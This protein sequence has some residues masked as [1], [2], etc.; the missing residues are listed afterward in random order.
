MKNTAVTPVAEDSLV[1][2]GGSFA[3]FQLM[4]LLRLRYPDADEFDRHVRVRPNLSFSFP[5]RDVQTVERLA[6]PPAHDSGDTD[7][8]TVA[9]DWRITANFFGLYGVSSPLPAFY[10][11]DLF[12]ERRVGHSASRDFLDVIHAALYPILQG[13]WEKYRLWLRIGERGEQGALDLLLALVG[14]MDAAPHEAERRKDA[15]LLPYASLFAQRP[16]SALALETLISGRLGGVAV[17]VVPCI[18]RRIAISPEARCQLGGRRPLGDMLLGDRLTERATTY[19]L[20][21]GPLD[22]LRFRDLLP[23]GALHCRL[24]RDLSLFLDVRL[25]CL[26][27]L[28]LAPAQARDATLGDSSWSAL[29]LDTWLGNG[30]RGAGNT[31]DT[32]NAVDGIRGADG[33]SYV[34]SFEL[35]LPKVT[36]ASRTARTVREYSES[37]GSSARLAH[38]D[39]RYFA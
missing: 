17:K 25:S 20:E 3:F 30:G 5:G 37:S 6:P 13:A 9:D 14:R 18:E 10:T 2:E 26:V 36:F 38:S 4:R 32:A 24:V 27:R 1:R 33:S 31:A 8:A 35:T 12:E 21:I 23:G 34:A 29:G 19:A 16:R 22:A 39:Q 28:H 7:E 11:E 15:S